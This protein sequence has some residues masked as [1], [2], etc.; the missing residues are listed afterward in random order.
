MQREL[1]A[2]DLA[3]LNELY[4]QP[5]RLRGEK[6]GPNVRVMTLVSEEMKPKPGEKNEGKPGNDFWRRINKAWN[7][8]QLAQ[9]SQPL[10]ESGIDLSHSHLDLSSFSVE[11]PGDQDLTDQNQVVLDFLGSSDWRNV[12]LGYPKKDDKTG[13]VHYQN[14]LLSNARGKTIILKN[15]PWDDRNFRL[16]LAELLDS[17]TMKTNG[18]SFSLDG[19]QF[20]YQDA[21][22]SGIESLKET[23]EYY[24]SPDPDMLFLN[25][26]NLDDWMS[27]AALKDGE[28][29]SENHPL[30]NALQETGCGLRITSKL[31]QQQWLRL[32]LEIRQSGN[33]PVPIYI[34][35]PKVQPEC[36]RP[37]GDEADFQE[38]SMEVE[39]RLKRTAMQNIIYIKTYDSTKLVSTLKAEDF[40][41]ALMSFVQ[42]YPEHIVINISP[43]TR[44]ESLCGRVDIL[45]MKQGWG[46]LLS[47][48]LIS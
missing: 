23:L 13:Q 4:D 36:F 39:A 26:K 46:F 20:Y 1:S 43:D 9:N 47:R 27:E 16:R 37:P 25:D 32:L 44:L 48:I 10:P 38:S 34:D 6:L 7:R 40:P 41:N 24:S 3:G 8:W 14:S 28:Q 29:P 5:P 17:S 42:C 19:C 12:L 15:A 11:Q 22:E 45:S 21:S 30:R 33:A 18:E 2:G 35:T 31:S